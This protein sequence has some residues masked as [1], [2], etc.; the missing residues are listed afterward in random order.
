MSRNKILAA[1]ALLWT[2]AV[3][4]GLAHVV[5]GDLVAPAVMVVLGIVGASWIV[6]RRGR[7]SLSEEG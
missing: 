4:D 1:G 2:V 7:G 6:L 5:S 3:A